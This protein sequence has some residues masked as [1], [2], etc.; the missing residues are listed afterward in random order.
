MKKTAKTVRAKRISP[1]E[2]AAN[3]IA[4]TA[5]SDVITFNG[6]TYREQSEPFLD[7]VRAR[8]RRENV[9]LVLV[10]PGGVADAAYRIARCLQLSYKKFT[11]L[12]PGWC[13]S[14]GTLCTLGAHEV[15]MTDCAELGP[16]DVQLAKTDE[17][18][19]ATSGLTLSEAL[20][21]MK[22]QAFQMYESYMLRI[23]DNSEGMIS[24]KVASDIAMHLV[25]GLYGPVYGHLAPLHIGETFRSMRIAR[26]YGSRLQAKSQNSA[27]KTLEMLSDTYP[28]HGF[29][30]DLDEAKRLFKRAREPNQ[31]E[32]ALVNALGP[33]FRYP[34]DRPDQ[35]KTEYLGDE[36][37]RKSHASKSKAAVGDQ[38]KPR[39][40]GSSGPDAGRDSGR[41]MEKRRAPAEGAGKKGIRLV[42]R[43]AKA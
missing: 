18:R 25:S 30:I 41:P 6:H 16:L 8:R 22:E 24:F 13:K 11:V 23:I 14:A 40:R 37:E 15:V 29:V 7:M 26:A 10:T 35:S 19:V 38:H 2:K 43:A 17:L 21:A 42:P 32:L 27:T 33:E 1:S 5:D 20:R 36:L 39:A 9:L 31:Q 34:P 3:A 4:R 12:L 28:D